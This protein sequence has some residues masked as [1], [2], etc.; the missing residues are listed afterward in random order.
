MLLPCDSHGNLN[1]TSKTDSATGRTIN[2]GFEG[3]SLDRSSNMRYA[4]LQTATVQDGGLGKST[5]RY[6][7]LLTFVVSNPNHRQPLVG[8][9]VV[10]LPLNSKGNTLGA[11]ELHFIKDGVFLALSRDGNGH[12]G[13]PDLSPYMQAD[14]IPTV[15]L[16]IG[17]FPI[18]PSSVRSAALYVITRRHRL[19][20]SGKAGSKRHT[21]HAMFRVEEQNEHSSSP[22]RR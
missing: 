16:L 9:W 13:S 21:A 19:L 20:A 4:L 17:V 2:S 14:S 8:E 11:S 18:A 15:G 5:S 22:R 10:P 3:L 1:F 7:R 6:T 12:G